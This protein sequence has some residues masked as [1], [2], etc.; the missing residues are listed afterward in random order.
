MNS[1]SAVLAP[2]R[3]SDPADMMGAI[4][5]L[6]EQCERAKGIGLAA[7]LGD[8]PGRPFS[9][10]VIAG[11]GGSAIGGDLLRSCYAPHLACPV[12]VIR[13]YDLPAH[14][15]A[16]TLVFASSNSGN[17]VETL[18]AY[19]QAKK[20]GATVVAFTTGGE[21][22]RRAR[23]D[24]VPVVTFPGGLQPRAA[25][26][27]SFIPLIVASARIGLMSASLVDDIDE[28][29]DALR[30]VRD[31]CNPGAVDDA[32]EARRLAGAWV[33]RLPVIYGSDGERGPA[34]YRWK[35]QIN[36]NAKAFAASNVFPEL[37]HNET[38]GW[39]GA[40]GQGNPGS[41]LAV[42]ILRDDRE[43]S[44]IRRRVELTKEIL[45]KHTD[46]ID[47]VWAVGDSAL[48]RMFSLIYVGDFASCYLAYAYAEDPT[49]V[50]AI[51]WLKSELAK[52][53]P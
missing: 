36:E 31:R 29:I 37:N 48:A 8:L 33:G 2:A 44:H 43:P 9:S 3:G 12:E 52:P 18:S 35:T 11:L 34:A 4:L 15:G 32:N 27:N 16:S 40:R 7:C 6:P 53:Y 49:P 20:R 19:E 17:T 1:R 10:V 23:E 42:C 5:G 45:A 21:L 22:G 51:D 41:L 30:G 24:R 13:D 25:L 46:R 39:S 28:A 26:G 50:G 14:V 38:L 47:E